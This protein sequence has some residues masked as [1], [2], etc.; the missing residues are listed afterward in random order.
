MTEAETS[1]EPP[2]PARGDSDGPPDDHITVPEGSRSRDSRTRR[3]MRR[4]SRSS[5]EY[6]LPDT[7]Q[8]L[9]E[10]AAQ[11]P[12]QNPDEESLRHTRTLEEVGDWRRSVSGRRSSHYEPD[13]LP[14]HLS[15]EATARESRMARRRSSIAATESG[16][17]V[18]D[19]FANLDEMM[20]VSPVQN[21]DE[22]NIY[23]H[24]SLEQVRTREQDYMHEQ[25]R[26][27]SVMHERREE[28]VLPEVEEE[29]TEKFNVSRLATHIYT[30]SYL[31]F[32]SILGTL[33]RLGL[34]A[35][36]FYPGAPAVFPSI[37]PNFG[38]SL[39]LGFL[40]EDR[41]L[42]RYE[43]GTPTS[44]DNPIELT[45]QNGGDEE[46][47]SGSETL[48]VNMEAAKKA[49]NATK[50]TIPLYI[51]LATGFCGS[52]T[53]FSSF[54]RDAFLA[55]SNDLSTPGIPS[56]ASRN[57]GYSFMALLAVIIL[58]VSLS[59][60]GLFIGAHIAIAL[61]PITPTLPYPL[62]RKVLDRIAVLL[63]CGCW[64][65]AILLTALPPDRHSGSAETWRGRA[66]FA[67]AFAPLG[68]LARFY[69]S[70]H[71]NGR[72]AAF[73]LGTF[74]VN[75]LGTA[76]LAAAWVVAHVPLGG[77]VGCQALQGV[78]DGFCGCL[79][80]VSTWVAELAALRRRHA[81]VYG[82]ASVL[83]ALAVAVVAMGGLLW[84]RGFAP[85]LCIH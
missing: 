4:A 61:E 57:G 75:V 31:I 69:A 12:V 8:N 80:T 79:T 85:L 3:N 42:F 36:T 45:R 5:V 38:G 66:T 73:P 67:L 50:K 56:N 23:R 17:D 33:A 48:P 74:A 10:V 2:P 68:C 18:P 59:L 78:E 83:V 72:V 41:M 53:S 19:A 47:A 11:P 62:T 39:F 70:L 60:T 20:D 15:R 77:V 25:R 13:D 14:R 54:I 76:V 34:Q 26:R 22:E 16:Y 6:D 28:P 30:I 64:V 29:K 1:D 7:F 51:G 40:A 82:S 52:F 9:D 37:W 27:S 65:G 46:A 58:T 24:K 43:W 32:F 21:P 35:I 44:F 84:S 63:G 71:L 81:Y 49:H 55:L